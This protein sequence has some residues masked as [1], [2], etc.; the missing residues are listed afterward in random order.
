[1]LFACELSLAFWEDIVLRT[2]SSTYASEWYWKSKYHKWYKQSIFHRTASALRQRR[3]SIN[4]WF[5]KAKGPTKKKTTL[6]KKL[7]IEAK[8]QPLSNKTVCIALCWKAQQSSQQTK[9]QQQKNTT[10]PIYVTIYGRR[11]QAS[12]L[13]LT[14]WI[15]HFLAPSPWLFFGSALLSTSF[16]PQGARKINFPIKL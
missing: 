2:P 6:K 4:L 5:R 14:Q 11:I 13:D 15:S 7:N 8:T 3:H 9:K 16:G 10:K 12:R 1:M